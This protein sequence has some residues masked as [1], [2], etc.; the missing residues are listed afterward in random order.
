M[1]YVQNSNLNPC[2]KMESIKQGIVGTN[3]DVR[4]QKKT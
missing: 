2:K 1:V 3:E 4:S